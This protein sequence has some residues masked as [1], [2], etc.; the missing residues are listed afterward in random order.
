[1]KQFELSL[2]IAITLSNLRYLIYL[3]FPIAMVAIIV[4]LIAGIHATAK[5][6]QL[7]QGNV[8]YGDLAFTLGITTLNMV[9]I[10][11]LVA[12][13]PLKNL[14]DGP[15]TWIVLEKCVLLFYL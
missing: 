13:M 11:T 10:A 7:I 9:I 1:M 6:K 8:I 4:A 14:S 3:K 2:K 15:V 12:E 5:V